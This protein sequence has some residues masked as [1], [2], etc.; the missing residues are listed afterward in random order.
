[1]VKER[2]PPSSDFLSSPPF[3]ALERFN[4]VVTR[5]QDAVDTIDNGLKDIDNM[6]SQ[7]DGRFSI[8]SEGVLGE[9]RKEH[10][11]MRERRFEERPEAESVYGAE[12]KSFE[13]QTDVDYCIEC[14]VKH[15]QTAKVL[16]REALQRAEIGDPGLVGVKEK[17][18]GVVEEL[19][20]LEDDTTTVDNERVTGLN[21]LARQ[22]RKYIYTTG[23]EV[24]KASMEELRSVKGMV[25]KLVE[26]SY[27]VRAF[28]ECPA[29]QAEDLCGGDVECLQFVIDAAEKAESVEEWSRL[30]VEAKEKYKK[31]SNINQG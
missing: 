2:K 4:S 9:A 6:T 11:N 14:A 21:N 17:V 27:T 13:G 10:L 24:G 25:D 26:A 15:S 5:F 23:A 30:M 18:R 16:M 28:E 20:G 19:C 3:E 12:A 8:P 1:M 7:I 22:L 31:P 29:C